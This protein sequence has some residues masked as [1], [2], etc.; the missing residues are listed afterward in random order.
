[1]CEETQNYNAKRMIYEANMEKLTKTEQELGE[2]NGL[3][4]RQVCQTLKSVDCP[5]KIKKY[6]NDIVSSKWFDRFILFADH[7]ELCHASLRQPAERGTDLSN[8]IRTAD[9]IFIGIF[10]VEMCLKISVW[11]CE[12][13]Q[14]YLSDAWN[15]MDFV[16]VMTGL[17]SYG[18]FG[19]A[20]R[21][22]KCIESFQS[23][24][25][26]GQPSFPVCVC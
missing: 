8:F 18:N 23:A 5:S 2:G 3:V 6:S 22:C 14:L 1:M 7:T 20:N 21:K 26:A 10:V 19:N 24:S 15:V 11:L 25:A 9:Y 13:R 12:G 17:L 4:T 16:I